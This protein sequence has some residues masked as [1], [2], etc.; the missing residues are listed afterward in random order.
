MDPALMAA[1]LLTTIIDAVG[2]LFYFGMAK[3]ILGL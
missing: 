3:I 2:L 1:P